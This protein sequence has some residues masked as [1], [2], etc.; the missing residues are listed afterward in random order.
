MVQ[1]VRKGGL[2]KLYVCLLYTSIRHPRGH[3][4]AGPGG[5]FSPHFS[6]Q[7]HERRGRRSADAQAVGRD[8]CAAGECG[9]SAVIFA[10][11]LVATALGPVSYTHLDVYKR[12]R[13]YGGF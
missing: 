10:L 7:Q 1:S 13:L 11:L 5:A 8:H 6:G 4:R 9:M 2:A 12:Q 3:Q